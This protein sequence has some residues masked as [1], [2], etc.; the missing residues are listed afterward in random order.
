MSKFTDKFLEKYM[1]R[2]PCSTSDYSYKLFIDDERF[3]PFNSGEWVIVRSSQEAIEYVKQHGTPI[4][5]SYD[6]DL[7]GDDTSIKFIN[8][9]IE[10]YLDN[11]DSCITYF[12]FPV[13][14]TIHS[15][16]PV[17]AA[18]IKGLID[19]FVNRRLTLD[20]L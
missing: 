7:G 16:N 2:V 20:N 12:K 18:N 9:M 4:F 19:G 15:Q 5:I 6:H 13:Y 14:Y 17:G 3:P 10:Y 1:Y 8:W 11:C